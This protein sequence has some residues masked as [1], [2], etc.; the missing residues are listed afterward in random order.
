MKKSLVN[1]G[2]IVGLSLASAPALA[3]FAVNV[4]AITVMPSDSSGS[5]NVIEQVA[6]LPANSTA[7]GV[8][9]NTQLGLTFD[10]KFNN[11][12]GLQLIAATPFSHDITAKGSIDGLR[13]GETKHL[14]PTLLAQYYFDLGSTKFQPF[15]G[16]GI[17]Y[18][19]FF[20]TKANTE[21]VGTLES[22]GVTTGADKVSI[23]LKDSWGLA[24][25]AG[26]NYAISDSLGFHFMVSKMQLD[27][28][29]QV[30]VNGNS[31][32]QVNV[33]IDPTVVMFGLRWSI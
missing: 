10:Y 11:N 31:V 5:L 30:R 24:A 33:T 25:Q 6:S 32:Q 7:V 18:T 22:L 17:N 27:T 16:L 20:S 29:A 21:L 8:N 26:F 19:N 23:K 9:S 14:P 3:N 2:M 4:G 28:D 13:I 15:V 12:W 1:L